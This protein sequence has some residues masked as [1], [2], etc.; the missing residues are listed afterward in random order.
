MESL[1]FLHAVIV[2]IFYN[3]AFANG[4]ENISCRAPLTD[5]NANFF[6]RSELESKL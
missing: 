2:A 5:S 4:L 6:T 3:L 1:V